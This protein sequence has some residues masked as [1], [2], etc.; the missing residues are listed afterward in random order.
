[1]NYL[2]FIVTTKTLS[3]NVTVEWERLR[4]L[5]EYTKYE[6]FAVPLLLK[7]KETNGEPSV[8]HV[9][10]FCAAKANPVTTYAVITAVYSQWAKIKV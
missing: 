10:S 9:K 1:M 3:E 2:V 7:R 5:Q 8:V 4:K 6:A